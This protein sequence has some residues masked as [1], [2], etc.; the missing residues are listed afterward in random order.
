MKIKKAKET[1]TA[2]IS[3]L[4][5]NTAKAHIR[6]EFTDDGWEL[7]QRLF[8][9]DCQRELLRNKQYYFLIAEHHKQI[10][11]MLALKDSSHIFQFFISTGWQKQGVGLMLWKYYL[12]TLKASKLSKNHFNT[13]TVN[14]SDFGR[15]FYLK[16]G[17]EIA[18]KRQMK[19]GVY[20]NPL[21]YSLNHKQ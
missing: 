14:A 2:A 4:I 15:G 1:D 7:F 8:S 18:G 13:I 3:S 21:H 19:K 9:E 5:L 12:Q 10:I 6:D 11:G 16:L 17:F 20:F